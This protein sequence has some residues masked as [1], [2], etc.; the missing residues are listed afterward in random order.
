M[1][2]RVSTSSTKVEADIHLKS[3][4]GTLLRHEWTLVG[5]GPLP[6]CDEG[7]WYWTCVPVLSSRVELEPGRLGG[8]IRFGRH[9]QWEDSEEVKMTGKSR[10]SFSGKW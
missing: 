2:E 5:D 6:L 7:P 4:S 1:V 10:P 3:R 9:L 8:A